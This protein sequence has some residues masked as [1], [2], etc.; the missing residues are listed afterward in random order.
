MMNL[1]MFGYFA[2]TEMFG[3]MTDINLKEMMFKDKMMQIENDLVPFGFIDDGSEAMEQMQRE[4][5]Q[6]KPWAIDYG[7]G[8]F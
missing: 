8:H 1:V 6:G 2:T 3:D 7:H 4:E 5:D